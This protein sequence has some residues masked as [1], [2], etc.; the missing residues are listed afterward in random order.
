M[1]KRLSTT[2]FAKSYQQKFTTF[3]IH[4]PKFS[5]R[6]GQCF[7]PRTRPTSI[8]LSPASHS[9]SSKIGTARGNLPSKTVSKGPNAKPSHPYVLFRPISLSSIPY[10][11]GEILDRDTRLQHILSMIG[12]TTNADDSR[13]TFQQPSP[14]ISFQVLLNLSRQIPRRAFHSRIFSH[15]SSQSCL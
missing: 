6:I 1:T 9:L 4:I 15:D 14:N 3:T 7:S 2:V 10:H 12:R 5:P 8:K 11:L 13:H